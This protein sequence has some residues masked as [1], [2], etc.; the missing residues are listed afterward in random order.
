M[1]ISKS[2]LLLFFF[3]LVG[4]SPHITISY[5]EESFS[6]IEEKDLKNT[7]LSFYSYL[8][9]K[10]IKKM[11]ELESPS[12]RYL[13]PFDRYQAYYQ[14]FKPITTISL[15]EVNQT[16]PQVYVTKLQIL[17]KEGKKVIYTDTWEKLDNKFFHHT[18]DPFF[19]PN[20]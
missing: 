6:K 13:Y 19:F 7:L 2:L 11:Y 10:N 15:M 1:R 18:I 8:N 16:S 14:G 3:L 20:K 9:E 17:L 4:C 12:F 5:D